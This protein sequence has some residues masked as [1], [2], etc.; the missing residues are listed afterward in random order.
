[1][2][3]DM[4][5]EDEYKNNGRPDKAEIVRQWRL[6]HP[7]GR[8]VDCIKDTGLSKPTVYKWWD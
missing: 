6:E 5:G 1:M 4:L 7:E 3:R 8:K 2:K